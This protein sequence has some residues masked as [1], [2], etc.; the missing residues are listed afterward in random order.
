MSRREHDGWK[1]HR[2]V[3]RLHDSSIDDEASDDGADA[4]SQGPD[5]APPDSP[6]TASDPRTSVDDLWRMAEQ[7]RLRA[8]IV[9]NTSAPADLINEIARVGG[10]G[11]HHALAILR[12]SLAAPGSAAQE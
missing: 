2:N 3:A 12:E 10:P 4:D 8:W 9:A 6:V 11:V 1:Q 5:G 7:P